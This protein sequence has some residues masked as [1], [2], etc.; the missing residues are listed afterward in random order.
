MCSTPREGLATH[1]LTHSSRS[2]LILMAPIIAWYRSWACPRPERFSIPYHHIIHNNTQ[3][4]IKHNFLWQKKFQLPGRWQCIA[5][6][7]SGT[8]AA[9]R[10]IKVGRL[11]EVRPAFTHKAYKGDR[12]PWEER[13][14]NCGKRNHRCAPERSARIHGNSLRGIPILGYA[15]FT[16]KSS[17]LLDRM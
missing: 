6:N 8:W 11:I 2:G 10:Q 14:R 7:F 1:P 13:S 3:V 5:D 17:N 9:G 4:R 12:T 15:S 16:S